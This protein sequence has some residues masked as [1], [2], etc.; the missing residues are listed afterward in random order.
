MKPKLLTFDCYGTLIDWKSGVLKAL[1][2]Y[3]DVDRDAF[4][5]TWWRVDRRWTNQDVYLPYREILARDFSEAFASVGVQVDGDDACC[6]ADGLGDW[7]PFEDASDALM[8]FR[9]MGFQL[10]IL[11]NIDND[12]LVR[13]V[14]QLGVEM[15]VWVTAEDVRA[16]KPAT[17]HFEVLLEQTGYGVDEVLHIAASR[18]VDIDPASRLGFR[19]MYVRRSEPDADYDVR[20]DFTVEALADAVPI[21]EQMT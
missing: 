11:S 1:V 15:D 9:E 10:G 5:E 12:L 8:A 6:L 13:S 18:F 19:T 14:A 4:F 17:R 21:L 7:M 16:Y 2:S 20:P 3:P